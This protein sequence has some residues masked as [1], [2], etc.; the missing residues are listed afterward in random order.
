MSVQN[1]S[2]GN[3]SVRPEK[4]GT[5]L[6]TT[7]PPARNRNRSYIDLVRREIPTLDDSGYRNYLSRRGE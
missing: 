4:T 2:K 3:P 7:Q 5:V 6:N 1:S